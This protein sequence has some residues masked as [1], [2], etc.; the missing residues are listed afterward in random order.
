MLNLGELGPHPWK[1]KRAILFSAE[2][3][4]EGLL[5]RIRKVELYGQIRRE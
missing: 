2:S 4:A 3:R 5:E 1:H